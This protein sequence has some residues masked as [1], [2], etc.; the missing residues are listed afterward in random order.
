[1]VGSGLAFDLGHNELLHRSIEVAGLLRRALLRILEMV[2]LRLI[3]FAILL[4][5]L[6]Y[7]LLV[8]IF[9]VLEVKLYSTSAVRL[10][11]DASSTHWIEDHTDNQAAARAS[12]DVLVVRQL[13]ARDL[14]AVAA[15]ARV[16]EDALRGVP[17]HVLDLD[18]VVVGAHDG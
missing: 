16:V 10:H 17:G 7:A 6:A 12:R 14:K 5:P 18:L 1:M 13:P 11:L 4:A 15:W 2:V 3:V 8:I 9:L